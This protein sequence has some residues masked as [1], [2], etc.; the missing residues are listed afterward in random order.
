MRPKG[1]YSDR[2]TRRPQEQGEAVHS[3]IPWEEQFNPPDLAL[4]PVSQMA[5]I[6]VAFLALGGSLLLTGA[7]AAGTV[8]TPWRR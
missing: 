8:A 4:M 1:H 2:T 7:A 3:P 5:L 6:P